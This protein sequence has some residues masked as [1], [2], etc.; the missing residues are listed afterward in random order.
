MTK[1]LITAIAGYPIDNMAD[2]YEVKKKVPGQSVNVS[3]LRKGN[4]I[5]KIVQL[6]QVIFENKEANRAE[7]NKVRGE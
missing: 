4:K 1:T 3:I 6:R 7:V 5:D 2:Y